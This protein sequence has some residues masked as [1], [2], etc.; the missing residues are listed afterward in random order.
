MRFGTTVTC[1]GVWVKLLSMKRNNVSHLESLQQ[2]PSSPHPKQKIK[3][4]IYLCT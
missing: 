3:I 2:H 4:K 1:S